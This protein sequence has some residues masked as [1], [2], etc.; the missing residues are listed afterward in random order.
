VSG[1]HPDSGELLLRDLESGI[2]RRLGRRSAANE[3]ALFS[4]FSRDSKWVAYGWL[5]SAGR[6]ELRVAPVETLAERIV[7]TNEGD[8]PVQ[9]CAFTSDGKQVLALLVKAGAAHI[10]FISTATGEARIVK[11]L[12]GP[13]PRRLD[14]SP[15]GRWIA[16]RDKLMTSDGARE[17]PLAKGFAGDLSPV[18]SHDGSEVYFLAK[19][20]GLW[21]AVLADRKPRLI[22]AGVGRAYLQ[23]ATED[24]LLFVGLLA[25]TGN[26]F[27]AGFDA[28]GGRLMT[29]PE[30]I[31]ESEPKSGLAVVAGDY[32]A[33]GN[34]LWSK[35]S[36]SRVATFPRPITALAVTHDGETVAVA[37]STTLTVIS[38]RGRV[39]SRA[40]SETISGLAWTAD[41][42][43]LITVQNDSL[44]WWSATLEDFRRIVKV[45]GSIGSVT[46][47]SGDTAILFTAGQAR[48]EVW[49]IVVNER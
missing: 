24:G 41:S 1:V 2:R 14:L 6:H 43:H 32:Q 19:D 35:A 20:F 11:R 25:G 36:E 47:E 22:R 12:D 31:G 16:Y 46:L 27:R 26:V 9:P 23:G 45:S 7:F 18:F 33:R 29:E 37:Q 40:A 10:A 4:V 42:R 15:D 21:R 39:E 13:A 5:N 34:E 44:W 38:P 3:H 49:S 30:P 8:G 48:S 17:E 28:A